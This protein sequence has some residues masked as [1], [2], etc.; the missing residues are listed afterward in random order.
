[1]LSC[2]LL[3]KDKTMGISGYVQFKD[4][5]RL[6]PPHIL[7]AKWQE[8]NAWGYSK[9]VTGVV[10]RGEPR[11][12]CGMPLG[13]IDTGCID[14][15]P[16][17]MIG[18]ST[19]FNH[20]INPRL[21]VNLPFLGLHCAGSTWVLISDTLGKGET[22]K[23]PPTSM[24][25]PP[26][27]YTP[28][29]FDIGLE[30]VETA[31]SVDY[32][33]HYPL[34]D[35]EFTTTAPVQVGLRAWSPFIPGDVIAS[36]MPGVV[37]NVFLRNYSEENQKG[38]LAFSWPGFELT[39][40][41]EAKDQVNRLEITG[42]LKGIHVESGQKESAFEMG[43]V[44]AAVG[45]EAIRMGGPLNADGYAWK[46]MGTKLP[47]AG[48]GETGSSLAIDF[49]LRPG[50][51]KSCRLVF[52]WFAPQWDAVGAPSPA[53]KNPAYADYLPETNLFTHMYA[54]HYPD[55][56]ATAEKLA[57]SAD[58]ILGRIISWQEVLYTDPD[59]PGWLADSLIN[60]FH[61][62]TET[63]VWGQ[64]KAPIGEWCS[65][66][67]GLFGMNECP[68]G[69]PQIE[70]LP[71]SFYGNIPVV[72]F[73]PEAALSTLRGY[74]AYQFEDGR[75]PL[76]FGG[77]TSRAAANK[78]PYELTRPDPGYQTVLNGACYILM[79]DR[80]WQISG[81]DNLLLEFWDSLKRCN[82]FSMNLRPAYGLSQVVSMPTPG[83]DGGELGD[84]EWFEAPEPGW[85]GYVNHAGGVR[86][87]QV[88]AMRRMASAM[89]D[90][91]Y[92]EKCDRWLEAGAK[93][94]EEHLWAGE[95]Y[96]CFKE[97]ETGQKSDLVFG[98][99]LDG[100]WITDWHGLPGV[101][102]EDRVDQALKTIRNYNCALSQSGAVNYAKPDG[103]VATLGNRSYG[104]YSYF[105]P[106]VFML[107][108][109]FMYQGQ[110]EFGLDLLHRCLQNLVRWGY[111]W[112]GVN[113][114]R[115]DRD[116]GERAYGA[117][118]YQNMMLWSVPS[119]LKG[120][121]C[122]GPIFPGGLV[123]K[124]IEAGKQCHQETV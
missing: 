31:E 89:K 100:Q 72:Y 15:E 1:M 52:S 78:P 35:M 32:W 48:H 95:Y 43:Y 69:C 120:E 54:Q 14:I 119:A 62:I 114:T 71:C 29:Y 9:P 12:T 47:V 112:D 88:M 73:F 61:L 94:M 75:V 5:N 51:R 33:G 118:Y 108:S 20:L 24:A 123:N 124:V 34:L 16:N 45:E 17:G 115:G 70:V 13:G 66:E 3:I 81:E 25:F 26:L 104:P 117:D 63:S 67:D 58:K 82:D 98:Y 102:P 22:P 65:P 92:I 7:H 93:A 86:L 97:P 4:S 111:I 6:F 109:T 116:T 76:T 40:E 60:I 8:F 28:S 106:E 38:T 107:A 27:D 49:H 2:F 57:H 122:S 74:K 85:K 87:A 10:Y 23:K 80:Y 19:I 101:F 59:T 83:T 44:V 37:F 50:E 21:L 103:T 64:A 110:K 121:D 84:T 36:M 55:P 18:Y 113:T 11:P 96:L 99:Q 105:P 39:N 30:G 53:S 46:E 68:R 56:L 91:E 90:R 41:T 79:F 42:A 77:H